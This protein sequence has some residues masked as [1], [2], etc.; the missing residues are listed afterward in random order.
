MSDFVS[1][2]DLL[3][4]QSYDALRDIKD[5]VAGMD[6][7]IRRAMD[8]GLAPDDMQKAQAARSAVQAASEI[9]DKIF[10]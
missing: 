4:E 9:L 5:D 7:D 3:D 10:V 8:C 2:M 1:V 6:M